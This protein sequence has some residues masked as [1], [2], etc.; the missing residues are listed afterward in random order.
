MSLFARLLAHNWTLK[1]SALALALLLWISVRVES[2]DRHDMSN[3]PVRVELT[4]PDW[5][6]AGDPLPTSVRVRFAGP[7]RELLRMAMDRPSIVIP[8]DRVVSGDTTVPLQNQ[9]VRIQDRPGV[10]VEDIQPPSIR[11]S[12]E[13]MQ[14]LSL[15]ASVRTRGTLPA[16]LALA[17]P[18]RVEPSGVQI[19][20]PADRLAQM[21]SVPLEVV[22][23]GSVDSADARMVSVDTSALE[24]LE[25][26]PAGVSVSFPVESE[27]ER[28]V[29]GIPVVLRSPLAENG[30]EVLPSNLTVTLTGARSLVEGLDPTTLSAVAQVEGLFPGSGLA[31]GEWM[32]QGSGEGA[33]GDVE[34]AEEDGGVPPEEEEREP[35]PEELRV[36]ITV[37]G[38]P[39][40]VRGVPSQDS[41]TLRPR[42][43][44]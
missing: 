37:E 20:G 18:P 22:D 4:D 32:F 1:L 40:L 14:R 33:E 8:V 41:V 34:G 31:E 25:V 9:W 38:I 28:V 10:T 43:E 12:F 30:V 17:G 11:L 16:G 23:L 42:P 3:I 7:S 6:M 27:V 36:P 21:D 15:P 44:T 2:P 19:A 29:S 39:P 5:A 35:V 26:V 24:G 13:A